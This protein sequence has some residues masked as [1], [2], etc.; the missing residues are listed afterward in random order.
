MDPFHAVEGA[1]RPPLDGERGFPLPVT[2]HRHSGLQA[3][4]RN[5]ESLALHRRSRIHIHR[6]FLHRH[7]V[8]YRAVA[9]DRADFGNSSFAGLEYV[10][11]LRDFPYAS[12]A[13][14]LLRLQRPAAD[15][16]F[17]CRLC[18]RTPGHCNWYCDV[19][20]SGK[21][22]SVVRQDLWWQ[23]VGS[24]HPFPHD[25]QFPGFSCR[26]RHAGCDDRI[27]EE[28]EPHRDGDG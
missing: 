2:D 26:A 21:S 6:N 12:G 5:R 1:P 8:R 16:L 23:A 3:H 9:K 24:I 25:A 13:K 27:R 28:H 22:F 19:T 14:R 18:L 17:H 20:G 15:C 7:A 11:A 4:D 10:G